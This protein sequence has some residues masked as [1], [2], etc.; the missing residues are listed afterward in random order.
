VSNTT[1]NA[2]YFADGLPYNRLGRGLQPLVV[3][4][5]LLLENKPPSG[6]LV[7][8]LGEITAPTLVIAGERDP[9]YSPALFRETA[10]PVRTKRSDAV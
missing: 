8:R 3:F 2:G 7:S 10:A 5:G 9:F 1:P 4:Q 6:M